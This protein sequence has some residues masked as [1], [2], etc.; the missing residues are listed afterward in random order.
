[1]TISAS[2]HYETLGLD[3]DCT[4]ADIRAAYRS[5]AKM[6]HPDVNSASPDALAR[7]QVLNDA[8]EILGDATKRRV[9]NEELVRADQDT[10]KKIRRTVAVNITTVVQISVLDFLRGVTL[11][12]NVKDPANP[13]GMETY[14]LEVPPETAPGA[15]FRLKRI[16]PFSSGHV[17]VRVKARP[18]HRFKTRGSDLRCDLR[19]NAR[20]ATSGGSE[21][22]RG[23]TGNSIFV[24]IPPNVSRGEI[25][26]VAGEGLPK[27]R[28]GRG[29]LL[30]RIMYRPEVRITRGSSQKSSP[31]G[32]GKQ[33]LLS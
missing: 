10:S 29:D 5:L 32:R 2:N 15:R 13:A 8:Y 31:S 11:N 23:A 16:A 3:R 24:K 26:R 17:L 25:I 27:P 9:Y 4:A 19:I 12:V 28:G 21:S 22:I 7:I 1:M 18:D 14:E 6:H 20:R 33:R 30:V